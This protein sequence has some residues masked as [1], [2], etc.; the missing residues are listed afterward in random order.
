MNSDPG[1]WP[2]VQ[3]R[4]TEENIPREWR[5]NTL[6]VDEGQDFETEWFE[7]LKLF[8]CDEA[9]I[10]WL[11]DPDQSLRGKLPVETTG[12]VHYN[13]PINYRSPESITHFIRNTLPFSFESYNHLPGLGVTVHAF[14]NAHDQPRIVGGII[15]ELMRAGFS[16]DDLVVLTCCGRDKSIFNDVEQIGGLTLRKFT[17]AYDS[18]GNQIMTHR[19]LTFESIYRYKGHQAP[20]IILVDVDPDPQR[21]REYQRLLYCGLTRATIR[22]DMLVNENNPENLRFLNQ[23]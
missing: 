4:V 6:I 13:S 22:V 5:F 21:K 15:I 20:A 3:D 11:E 12:F 14:S 1:F 23:P 18:N 9:D 19:R 8:L 16:H 17:G 7:I 10:L 2:K